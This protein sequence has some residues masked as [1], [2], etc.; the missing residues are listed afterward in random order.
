MANLIIFYEKPGALQEL[1]GYYF[2]VD[3]VYFCF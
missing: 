3:F 2:I 1:I